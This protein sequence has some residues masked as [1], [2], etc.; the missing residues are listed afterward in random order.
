MFKDNHHSFFSSQ[1][2]QSEKNP[3]IEGLDTHKLNALTAIDSN[4]LDSSKVPSDS[5]K[6]PFYL[7]RD[8]VSNK[9]KQ[10]DESFDFEFLNRYKYKL[11]K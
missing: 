9:A 5:E 10:L 6:I 4:T 8:H 7:I 1:T 11:D 2:Q 3:V